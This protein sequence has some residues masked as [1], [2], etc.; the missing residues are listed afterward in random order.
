[1]HRMSTKEILAESF[2]ELAE[3]KPINKIIV[4]SLPECN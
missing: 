1:M 2:K 4:E 3:K